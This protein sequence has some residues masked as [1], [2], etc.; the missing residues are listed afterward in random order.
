MDAGTKKW[1]LAL[2]R[3]TEFLITFLLLKG[4]ELSALST[5]FRTELS[6]TK[7]ELTAPKSKGVD[8]HWSSQVACNNFWYE[9]HVQIHNQTHNIKLLGILAVIQ[10]EFM[11]GSSCLGP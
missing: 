3:E 9:L 5:G 8:F 6:L 7:W 2:H 10:F 11:F 1:T 4:S